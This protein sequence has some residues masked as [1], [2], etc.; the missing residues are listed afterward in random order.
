MRW[1]LGD[2]PSQKEVLEASPGELGVPRCLHFGLLLRL[3]HALGTCS[4]HSVTSKRAKS[5]CRCS[6]E[7][8]Y[9]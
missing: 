7:V 2:L 1:P 9:G 4:E 8:G 6:Q 3:R 5:A